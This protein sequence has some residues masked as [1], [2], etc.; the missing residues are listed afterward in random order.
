MSRWL[1]KEIIKL[2]DRLGKR[3][4][5]KFGYRYN[6]IKRMHPNDGWYTA[7]V[8]WCDLDSKEIRIKVRR[9]KK[10][11]FSIG[12]LIDTLI[13]EI[14]HIEDQDEHVE[15]GKDWEERYLKLQR[16]VDEY[17]YK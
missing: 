9:N 6:S 11:F 14:A 16:W 15:H 5:K 10:Q 2:L 7:C 4:C 17:I 3:I 12:F 1:D 8:G 13:H